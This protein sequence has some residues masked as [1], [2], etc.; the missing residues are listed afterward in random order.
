M[1][2]HYELMKDATNGET[3]RGVVRTQRSVDIRMGEPGTR[4]GVSSIAE[5]IGYARVTWRT[6]TSKYPEEKK[7][8]VI[9]SVAAS[10]RGGAQTDPRIGV[11]G[12][13][14]GTQRDSRMALKGQPEKVQA[15]YTK[16]LRDL[17]GS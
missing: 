11:V 7:T 8:I 15:L 17:A 13:R 6:E 10:E 12:L 14:H 2:W 5:Y 4:N 1:P 9:P 3:R 16:S